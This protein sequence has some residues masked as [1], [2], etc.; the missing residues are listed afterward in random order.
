MQGPRRPLVRQH[1]QRRPV[2]PLPDDGAEGKHAGCT[3]KNGDGYYTPG[4]DVNRR[5]NDAWGVRDII[6]GGH[7]FAGSFQSWFVKV[8]RDEHRV[9][10]PLPEDSRLR[11]RFTQKG[12]YATGHAQYELRPF[13][14]AELAQ[15][16]PKLV[17]FIADKEY[18]D[19]PYVSTPKNLDVVEWLGHES[20][21]RSINFSLRLDGRTGF[22]AV[23]P[24]FLFWH[25][26]DSVG[27]GWIVNRIYFMDEGL[28]D[29][30]WNI[31]YTP[32]ASRWLDGYFS[33]GYER[34]ED[35]SGDVTRYWVA[36]SGVKFRFDIRHSKASFLSKI[37]D[38][39]GLRAGVQASGLL[40]V[41]HW[42]DVIEVG[43]GAF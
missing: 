43:G 13:P 32:S 11:H 25:F 19:W 3:D 9:F 12:E 41:D 30:S 17:P 5:A 8:R 10:P 31:L 27:G 26:S 23:F 35:D 2:H 4:Y 7:L 1:A 38:F 42:R 21:L 20:F 34:D 40:P 16:D 39:W 28:R 37:T 36:E 33:L 22:A 18:P 15:A 24:L 6:R 29:F 14:R